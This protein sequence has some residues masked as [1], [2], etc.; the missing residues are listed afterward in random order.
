MTAR[1]SDIEAHIENVRQLEAVVTAM[2]GIAAGRAQRSRALLTS[3]ESYAQIA[4]RA[5]GELMRVTP[6]F[7]GTSNLDGKGALI[8][9]CA[10]GGFCGALNDQALDKLGDAWKNSVV[11]EIGS[12]GA[13]VAEERGIRLDW[14]TA[15]ANQVGAVPEVA[16]RIARA[17]YFGIGSGKFLRAEVIYP[18]VQRD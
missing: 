10:E 1:L 12:R 5:I 14:T 15:M 16:E 3:I 8:V 2:R 18:R 13:T 7:R 4:A 9:F 11:F 6:G 17:L